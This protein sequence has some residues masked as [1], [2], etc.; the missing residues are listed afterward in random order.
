MPRFSGNRKSAKLQTAKPPNLSVE[1]NESKRKSQK[2]SC[3]VRSKFKEPAAAMGSLQ[4]PT[5]ST[6]TISGI[7]RDIHLGPD[8]TNSPCFT[9]PRNELQVAIMLTALRSTSIEDLEAIGQPQR[10][11]FF[12]SRLRPRIVNCRKRVVA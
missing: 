5:K 3:Q 6:C 12:L 4:W 7:D 10:R 2:S 11:T 1:S 9:F 8:L